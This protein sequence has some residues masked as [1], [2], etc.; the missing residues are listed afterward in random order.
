MDADNIRQS[1]KLLI[2]TY[3]GMFLFY[4]VILLIGFFLVLLGVDTS[5]E[6]LYIRTSDQLIN[7]MKIIIGVLPIFIICRMLGITEVIWEKVKLPFT[8]RS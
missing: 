1:F 3:L 2:F 6:Q 7:V 8:Y 5:I 4:I